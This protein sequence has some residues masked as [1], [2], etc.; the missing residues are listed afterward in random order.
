MQPSDVDL[1]PLLVPMP[2][3]LVWDVSVCN[4]IS[5][6]RKLIRRI[7]FGP[8]T[9]DRRLDERFL[10]SLR[11]PNTSR[12]GN[13]T[14]HAMNRENV[15]LSWKLNSIRIRRMSCRFL[16]LWCRKHR[17]FGKTSCFFVHIYLPLRI[18]WERMVTNRA[19]AKW[20]ILSNS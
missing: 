12:S 2:S 11:E 13:L 9:R 1:L 10:Y 19:K 6:G 16:N 18:F 7:S 20:R 5:S 15:R 8:N 3:H 14:T 17:H 4:L